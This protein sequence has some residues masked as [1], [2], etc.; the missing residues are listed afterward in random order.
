MRVQRMPS[1]FGLGLLLVASGGTLA[2]GFKTIKTRIDTEACR[3]AV[4]KRR[5][6]KIVKLEFKTERRT[7][8]YEFEV[9]SGDGKTWELA[10]D[11][12]DG[13]IVAIER[14]AVSADDPSFQTKAKISADVARHTALT[15]H[16]GTVVETEYEIEANGD[17]FYEFD[18]RSAEGLRI[19]LKVDAA[20]GVIVE[21]NEQEWNQIG[22][23]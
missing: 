18:I 3:D 10:C 1:G 15:A 13:K 14:E 9:L 19:K 12:F 22:Q 16:P 17:A 5:P 7:P 4:L 21:D 8:L 11:A 2:D 23:E 6:G 20:S